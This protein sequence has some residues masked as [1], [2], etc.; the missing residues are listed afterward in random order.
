MEEA[1]IENEREAGRSHLV[2]GDEAVVKLSLTAVT[3]GMRRPRPV[4]FGTVGEGSEEIWS[5]ARSG[6]GWRLRC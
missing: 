3:E 2:L 5:C 6:V 1:K 4:I